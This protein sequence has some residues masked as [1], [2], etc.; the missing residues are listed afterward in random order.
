MTEQPSE[1]AE[2]P[3]PG[4]PGSAPASLIRPQTLVHGI[5][6]PNLFPFTRLFRAFGVAAQPSM[7]IL[8]LAAILTLYVFGQALD[9]AWYYVSDRVVPGE[10]ELFHETAGGDN[11]EAALETKRE[12]IRNHYEAYQRSVNAGNPEGVSLDAMRDASIER[13]DNAIAAAER[14]LDGVSDERRADAERLFDRRV[15]DAYETTSQ[16]WARLKQIN[17]EGPFATTLKWQTDALNQ[18]VGS[19]LRLDIDGAVAAIGR[20]LGTGPSWAVTR[21]PVYFAIFFA[22][23]IAVLAVFG[24]ALT[25]IAAVYV[26]R[27]EKISI[28]EALKFSSGKF[29]SF[30]S[31]P[32]IPLLMLAGLGLAIALAG[33]L[34]NI[35]AIGPIAVGVGFILVLL[36]AM[37]M[38]LVVVG[39]VG[40]FN[41]MYPTIAV[42]GTDS[43]DA[44]SR[45]FSYLY[46]R[47]WTLAWYTLLSLLYGAVVYS[48][49]RLF[50]WLTLSLSHGFIGLFSFRKLEG[51]REVIPAVWDEAPSFGKL[52]YDIDFIALSFPQD[53]AAFF[54]AFWVY[55]AIG[56][57]G[58]F[59]MSLYFASSTIIYF[60]MRKD[61]DATE[62]DDVYMEEDIDDIFGTYD[63]EEQDAAPADTATA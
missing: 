18:L 36:G 58:A 27:D 24:G 35:P 7:L 60:L 4:E 47:P 44:I 6:W 1:P 45:S 38:S 10:V 55:L 23:K 12:S 28:R 59:A 48:V 11:F 5:D 17:G 25:R 61:V 62:L 54:I 2:Q 46:A 8:A 43:F 26:A 20:S 21:F 51:G 32:L 33:L 41:L 52:S 39:L 30:V 31:A 63:E 57:L 3:E 9:A 56:L 15:Q 49:F 19:L 50:V 22:F 42:E 13:R 37:V 53:I 34:L 29:L 40:G 14:A 16:D